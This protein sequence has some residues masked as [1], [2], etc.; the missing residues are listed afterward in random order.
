M[1]EDLYEELEGLLSTG[2]LPMDMFELSLN[3]LR[4][5]ELDYSSRSTYEPVDIYDRVSD[6]PRELQTDLSKPE[7]LTRLVAMS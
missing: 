4:G 6:V 3:E 5:V 1:A 7:E 2:A